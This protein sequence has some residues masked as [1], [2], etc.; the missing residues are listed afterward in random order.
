MEKNL[1][2]GTTPRDGKNSPNKDNSQ[3]TNIQ[4]RESSP[5]KDRSI[6][7]LSEDS[8]NYIKGS[9]SNIGGGDSNANNNGSS[10]NMN[11]S[12]HIRKKKITTIK[13]KDDLVMVVQ[14]D[15]KEEK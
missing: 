1:G 9:S 3:P 15:V 6:E 10:D 5:G 12:F 13:S 2:T 8:R 14:E 11:R 4:Y 7:P